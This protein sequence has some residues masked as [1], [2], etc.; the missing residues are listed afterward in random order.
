MS[1]STVGVNK[2]TIQSSSQ[3]NKRDDK[4]KKENLNYQTYSNRVIQQQP[5]SSQQTSARNYQ[6]NPSNPSSNPSAAHS[7]NSL[8]Y[9]LDQKLAYCQ[10]EMS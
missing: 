10:A 1:S 3:R 2:P 4:E 5:M 6:T 9:E 8:M 7:K